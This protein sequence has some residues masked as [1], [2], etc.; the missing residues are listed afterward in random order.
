VAPSS[1]F[2]AFLILSMDLYDCGCLEVLP[3]DEQLLS[4]QCALDAWQTRLYDAVSS[5]P[6]TRY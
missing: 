5:I 1:T 2:F 4:R 6:I 3:K